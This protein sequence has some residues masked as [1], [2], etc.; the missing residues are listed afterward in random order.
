LC[1][2]K[3]LI[4]LA[5]MLKSL[6]HRFLGDFVEGDT[7]NRDAAFFYRL[8]IM[9]LIGQMRGNGFTL[10]VRVRRKVNGGCALGQLL[11]LGHNFFFARDDVVFG[12]EVSLNVHTK[13]AFRQV[14][15]VPK[16]GFDFIVLTQVLVD[17][18]RLGRRFDDD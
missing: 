8:A 4:D 17:G 16:R 5:R 6:L 14:F 10:A 13:L 9:Q 15:D 2:H 11:Q 3:M 18:F 12:A 7:V 1:V